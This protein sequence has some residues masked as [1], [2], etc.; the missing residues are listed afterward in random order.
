MTLIKNNNLKNLKT[1][2]EIRERIKYVT[3][4]KLKQMNE[5]ETL[6]WVLGEDTL[7]KNI[8]ETEDIA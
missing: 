1:E 4:H 7:E 5:I 8:N 6:K 2:E 3:K